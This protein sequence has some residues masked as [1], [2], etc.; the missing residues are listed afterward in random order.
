MRSNPDLC[1]FSFRQAVAST[2]LLTALGQTPLAEVMAQMAANPE[3]SCILAVCRH[4]VVGHEVVG[5]EVV[6]HEVVGNKVVGIATRSDLLRTLATKAN[7]PQLQLSQVMSHPVITVSATEPKTLPS[8]LERFKQHRISHLPVIDDQSQLVGLIEKKQLLQLL[9]D[10]HEPSE[11][12]QQHQRTQLLAEITLKIRQSL[13][14]KEILQTTVDEVK[15]LLSADRVLIYQV[16][17]NG[18]GKTISEAVAHPYRSLLHIPFPEEVFP[19]NYQALYVKGRVQAI[20]DV[21]RPDSGLSKCLVEFIEQWQVRSKLIVPIVQPMNPSAGVAPLSKQLWGLL[22]AHQCSHPRQ[23]SEFELDLMQQLAG[24]INLA[25]SQGQLLAYLED[26]VEL[27]TAELTEANDA[28]QREIKERQLVEAALRHSEAQLRL[29]TN[30]LPVLI[31][32]VD[33][34]QCYQFNNEVYE[35]WLGKCPHSIAGKPMAAVVGQAHYQRIHGHIA[36]A[37]AGEAVSYES[38]LTF[39]DGRSHAVNVTYVPHIEAGHKAKNRIEPLVKGFFALTTDIS[40]RKAIERM[41]DEFIAIVSHELR[42]PLTSIHTSLK[43]L[44][45]GRLGELSHDGQQMLEV[46]DENTDRLVRLVNNVLDLQRIESGEVTM[47]TYACDAA[48]LLEQAAEAT[49]TMAQQH[50]IEIQTQSVSLSIWVDP[51]YIIRTLTNL[52]GN[53]IKYS[54]PPQSHSPHRRTLRGKT[55]RR[56][57]RKINRKINRNNPP[58]R[59]PYSLYAHPSAG[60]FLRARPWPGYPFSQAS[61]HL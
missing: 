29:I 9:H 31:A 7:W 20:A 24:Q 39:K 27:R 35:H 56:I 37:L 47:D 12:Y 5:H 33:R 59:S 18:T 45:T 30:N 13:Q 15:R 36:T 28:L 10:Q 40:D 49:H 54:P 21:H 17:P 6:G 50:E 23:W 22:I 55:C 4:E 61:G 42:T 11:P 57:N 43:L 60:A 53:A 41:K 58:S 14:L 25:L 48:E 3:A 32:Y 44:A 8:L 34:H 46:A 26:R 19:E 1:E 2:Q 16:W 38:E 51:D 52:I